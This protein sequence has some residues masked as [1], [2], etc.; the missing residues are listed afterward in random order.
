MLLELNIFS[1]RGSLEKQERSMMMRMMM[2]MTLLMLRL[3]P[4]RVAV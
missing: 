2:V 1:D 4:M 3:R